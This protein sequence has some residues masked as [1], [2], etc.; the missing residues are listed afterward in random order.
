MPNLSNRLNPN[1]AKVHSNQLMPHNKSQ[2]NSNIQPKSGTKLKVQ[3]STV[4]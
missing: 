1:P 3:N 4:N 2:N